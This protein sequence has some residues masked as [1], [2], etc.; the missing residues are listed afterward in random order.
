MQTRGTRMRSKTRDGRQMRKEGR[1]FF[2]MYLSV[3]VPAD[4]RNRQE[5]FCTHYNAQSERISKEEREDSEMLYSSISIADKYDYL[6][7]KFRAAYKWL[8]ETDIKALPVGRYKILGDEVVA[9][10]QEYE[11]KPKEEKN[12]EAHRKFFDVQYLVSG[13]EAFGICRTQDLTL[14]EAHEDKDLYFYNEPEYSGEIILQEG[15]FCVVAPED[16]HKPGCAAGKPSHV[17]KVVVKVAL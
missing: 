17:K 16:G 1:H 14:K 8:A 9:S 13:V 10:V 2:T 6:S 15:D 11:T 5:N 3:M 7:D 12:F 4:A